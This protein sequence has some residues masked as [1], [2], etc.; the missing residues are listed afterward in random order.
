IPEHATHAQC[1]YR[2]ARAFALAGQATGA[3]EAAGRYA[4][5]AV[6]LLKDAI[7]QG[8]DDYSAIAR[9]EDFAPL[10]SHLGF[11]QLFGPSDLDPRYAAVWGRDSGWESQEL[12]G[13]TPES[14]LAPC[15]DLG[16]QGFL[17][18]SIAVVRPPAGSD[19][20]AAST[21][22][23]PRIPDEAHD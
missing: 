1:L 16:E 12:H 8:F 6:A 5:R 21:W 4:D 11:R 20:V 18:A 10:R 3:G 14:H 7:T 15:R 13:L 23:R 19:L 22:R 9:E 17:P 2:Y